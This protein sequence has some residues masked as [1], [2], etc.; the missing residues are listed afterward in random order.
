MVRTGVVSSLGCFYGL[1]AFV[2]RYKI[3]SGHLFLWPP[4]RIFW[5]GSAAVSSEQDPGACAGCPGEQDW[6]I[7]LAC[8]VCKL[9]GERV[10]GANCV[11]V[12]AG[13]AGEGGGDP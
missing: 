11:A 3:P 12:Q 5:K 10:K 1:P 13:G 7:L 2:C 9:E 6:R 8:E 4:A